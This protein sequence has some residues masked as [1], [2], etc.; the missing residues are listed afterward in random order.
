MD[1]SARH[2]KTTPNSI[3][4][5]NKNTTSPFWGLQ[6]SRQE[7]RR[8]IHTILKGIIFEICERTIF[9]LFNFA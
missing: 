3:D 8:F 1:D 6:R 2:P 5:I 9:A 4:P 7:R